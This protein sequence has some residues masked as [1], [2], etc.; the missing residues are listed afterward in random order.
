[1]TSG[2]MISDEGRGLLFTSVHVNIPRKILV[3]PAGSRRWRCLPAFICLQTLFLQALLIRF[4]NL[5]SFTLQDTLFS[6]VPKCSPT[7]DS[8]LVCTRCFL[9]LS[10]KHSLNQ[11][12]VFKSFPFP[13]TPEAPLRLS[14]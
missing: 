3:G 13:F 7:V 12:V 6:L 14:C 1:M 4:F 5:C 10:C 9:C 8:S 11:N 2:P